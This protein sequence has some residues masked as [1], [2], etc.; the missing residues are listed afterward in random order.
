MPQPT[1]QTLLENIRDLQKIAAFA[2]LPSEDERKRQWEF[3][4]R[5]GVP[6]PRDW[7]D[8][9]RDLKDAQANP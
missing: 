5:V 7:I 6:R 8:D 3:L 4:T 9:L 1:N 2:D